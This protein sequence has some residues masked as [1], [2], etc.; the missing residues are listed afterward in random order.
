MA[1]FATL[2]LLVLFAVAACGKKKGPPP[3]AVTPQPA[4]APAQP[5]PPKAQPPGGVPAALTALLEAEWPGIKKNGEAFE[6]KF[7]EA[8]KARASGD[9][10]AMN[11][12]VEEARKLY[13]D[14]AEGW[15]KIIYWPDDQVDE[16]K[17]DETAAEAC[18]KYLRTYERTVEGWNK[19][20]KGLKEIST[21]K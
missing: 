7:E 17:M 10:E 13:Q 19:K 8:S 1:R 20:A 2:G 18:R 12:A 11:A 9:R 21:V 5:Q 3:A 15:A 14:A 6:A 4:Q 16:G